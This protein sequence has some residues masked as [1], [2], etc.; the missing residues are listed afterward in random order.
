MPNVNGLST[1][2]AASEAFWNCPPR[3]RWRAGWLGGAAEDVEGRPAPEPVRRRRVP[4][5]TMP[6]DVV[7]HDEAVDHGW[8]RRR[9]QLGGRVPAWLET[10]TTPRCWC[11]TWRNLC[12]GGERYGSNRAHRRRR[13]IADV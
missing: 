5:V 4:R 3:S 13:R 1:T 8:G 9:D 6:H 2:V 12:W 7:R 11:G 10:S